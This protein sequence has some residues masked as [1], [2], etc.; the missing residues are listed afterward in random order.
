MMKL[1]VT[2]LFLLG[3]SSSSPLAD[4]EDDYQYEDSDS[5]LELEETDRDHIDIQITSRP[6]LVQ[7]KVGEKI[8]LPCRVQ[9]EGIPSSSSRNDIN[10]VTSARAGPK[11]CQQILG[12]TR[13]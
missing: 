4:P 13:H 2:L 12:P 6:G 8:V 7:G 5:A 1:L 9:P 11:P 10:S 3:C